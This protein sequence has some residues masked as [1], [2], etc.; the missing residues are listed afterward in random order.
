MNLHEALN[1]R[2]GEHRVKT[3]ENPVHPEQKL[4]V[5]Y[6]ELHVPLTIIMTSSLSEY[7][8]PVTDKW[9][10]REYNELFF[11]LPAYWDLNDKDNATLTALFDWIY[12]LE[13]FVISKNT[14]FG[15]GHSI[16]CGNP[17]EAIS[18]I[19]KQDNF[20]LLDPMFLESLF[21][22]LKV[23]G[24]QVHLL[25]IVPV[26]SDELEYK[27]TK[28]THKFIRR[29]YQKKFDERI[30]EFRVSMMNSRF[31]LF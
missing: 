15:P 29:F 13:N 25:A 30:D 18:P 20:M 17:S 3:M 24:K 16:P 23:N 10:G 27:M 22:P 1:D 2:V 7:T 28:G 19:L 14:W 6:L 5:L 12:R 8:M 21:Q 11:A 4:V 9:K 31:K 26:F